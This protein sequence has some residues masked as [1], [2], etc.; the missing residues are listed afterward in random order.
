MRLVGEAPRREGEHRGG[1]PVEPL[2][3]VDGDDERRRRGRARAA[4]PAWRARRPAGPAARRASAT[5]SAISSARRCGAGR[6]SSAS[7]WAPSRSPSAAWAKLVSASVGRAAITRMPAASRAPERRLPQRRLADARLARDQ[8]RSRA[9]RHG[10]EEPLHALQLLVPSDELGLHGGGGRAYPDAVRSGRPEVG[11][12][13]AAAHAG[14]RRPGG[15]VRPRLALADLGDGEEDALRRAQPVEPGI[16]ASSARAYCT[17]PRHP[18]RRDLVA[19]GR[20]SAGRTGPAR[21]AACRSATSTT[22]SGALTAA[23]SSPQP[24]AMAAHEH[25]PVRIVDVLMAHLRV[26][27][28]VRRARPGPLAQ[29]RSPHA[30][31]PRR[32]SR[33]TPPRAGGGRARRPGGT[34]SADG[35]PACPRP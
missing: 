10:F 30:D 20:R 3:V 6:S 23:S 17:T 28:W 34:W 15:L 26:H 29:A 1:G 4:R 21:A 14:D 27:R 11:E 31:S 24:A 5:S 19:P 18:R 32:P 2:H 12:V 9:P 22:G 25:E 8:Q 7:G 13:L 16:L 33:P 35:A